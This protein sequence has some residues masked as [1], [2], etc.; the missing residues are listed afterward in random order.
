MV[1]VNGSLFWAIYYVPKLMHTQ[2]FSFVWQIT[3]AHK[4]LISLRSFVSK[5]LMMILTNVYSFFFY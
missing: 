4:L 2:P 3:V 5:R 1:V